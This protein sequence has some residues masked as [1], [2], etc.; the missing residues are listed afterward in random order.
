VTSPR[1]IRRRA[2]ALRYNLEVLET[3]LGAA[4]S[5]ATGSDGYPSLASGNGGSQGSRGTAE[6]T[7][8]ERAA[9]ERL[10][11]IHN[12]TT[13]K[14]R[15]GNVTQLADLDELLHGANDLI[16][17]AL[18]IANQMSPGLTELDLRRLRCCNYNDRKPSSCGQWTDPT[19]TDG[20]CVDCGRKADTE[21]RRMRRYA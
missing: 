13:G 1:A 6:L 17:R 5:A 4:L 8:V 2:T 7:S 11:D 21:A 9:H 10:G 3:R 12:G 18:Q 15:P 16:V 20:Q 19:R 14:Y